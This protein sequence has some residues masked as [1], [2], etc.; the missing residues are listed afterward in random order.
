MSFRKSSP[1]LCVGRIKGYSERPAVRAQFAGGPWHDDE[2]VGRF[3]PHEFRRPR[4]SGFYRL[5]DGFYQYFTVEDCPDCEGGVCE[6]QVDER[7]CPILGGS[8]EPVTRSVGCNECGGS[9]HVEIPD[10]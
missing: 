5:T 9:G 7:R 3:L 4:W 8:Y 6:I 10:E 2:Y 1:A